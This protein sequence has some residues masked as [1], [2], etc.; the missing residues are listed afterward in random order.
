MGWI[1]D[2][3]K[4][5]LGLDQEERAYRDRLASAERHVQWGSGENVPRDLEHALK[6]LAHCPVD[7][8]PTAHCLYRRHR[9]AAEAHSQLAFQVVRG[10]QD[11]IRKLGEHFTSIEEGR[12]SLLAQAEAL[13]G[14]VSDLEREGSLISAR[15]ER[16]RL[17]EMEREARELPDIAGEHKTKTLEALEE[18]TPRFRRHLDGANRGV[19]ALKE[20]KGLGA[21]DREIC[22]KITARTEKRL[23]EVDDLWKKLSSDLKNVLGPASAGPQPEQ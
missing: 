10:L 19:A 12:R 22:E 7:E 15:E 14:R 6:L 20:V 11:K 2:T 13:R 3:F 9:L 18:A 21:Q 5:L 4:A 17:E 1:G 8:A 23:A 16:R